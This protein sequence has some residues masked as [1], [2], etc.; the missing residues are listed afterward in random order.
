MRPFEVIFTGLLLV[1]A[2]LLLAGGARLRWPLYADFAAL[3]LALVAHAIWEGAHWQMA[4]AY[5][6]AAVLAGFLL[7]RMPA[8]G[9]RVS[10]WAILA[11]VLMACCFSAV[12]P[13]FRL[14]EPTGSSAIGTR[15]LSLVDTS[16]V[17][18]P[19]LAPDRKRELLIQIWYPAQSSSNPRA[20]YRRREETTLLSSYQSVLWTHARWNAPV[21]ATDHPYPVILFN[22]GWTGRRTSDTYLAEDLAS[23]GYVVVGIDHP[24]NTG[25]IAFP[26]GRVLRPQSPGSMDFDT[27]TIAQIRAV[28]DAEMT[29]QTADTLFVLD[30]LQATAEDPKSPFYRLLDTNDA[31]AM[32]FSFGGSVGAQA[33]ALDPRIRSAL[34]LDGSLF[35]QV[36]QTGVSKPFMFLQE[37]PTD[38]PADR[39]G[40]SNGQRVDAALDDGDNEMF[41]KSGGYR[42]Y[43]HGSRHESFTDAAIFSPWRRFSA[44]GR[45][46]PRR[47]FQI[48]RAYALA[49]FDQT[50][51]GHPSELLARKDSPFPEVTFTSALPSA[52]SVASAPA[53]VQP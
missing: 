13:M 51:K 15:I 30:Q 10:A 44:A 35:G 8:E 45:I 32:G 2:V 50:L 16:R 42:V 43:F 36:Q 12:L 52:Q 19:N 41:A 11:G 48:V 22:P 17:E 7:F 3:V 26:D 4:P 46:P 39:S 5:L 1:A 21:A 33:C 28:G 27:R 34:D 9:C 31:G 23:H 40:L 6:A 47:Q 49:F 20:P 18:D 25:P 53:A 38:L 14:P 29:R 24:Y 37:D